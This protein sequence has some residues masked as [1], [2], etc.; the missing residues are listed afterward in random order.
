[1]GTRFRDALIIAL[2]RAR[3]AADFGERLR[4]HV[5]MDLRQARYRE[6]FCTSLT[7]CRSTFR[8]QNLLLSAQ[9]L[10]EFLQPKARKS[11]RM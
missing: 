6:P 3:I 4:T 2:C 8:L 11:L 10:Q 1:M 5:P 7:G 9:G